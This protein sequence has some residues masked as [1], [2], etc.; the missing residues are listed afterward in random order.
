MRRS[1]KET[2]LQEELERLIRS[3][4]NEPV[5]TGEPMESVQLGRLQVADELR[6]LLRTHL[7]KAQA[8]E[9]NKGPGM[10]YIKDKNIVVMDL[11]DLE[12]CGFD[13]EDFDFELRA[14]GIRDREARCPVALI[15][16]FA[17]GAVVTPDTGK[18]SIARMKEMK[19]R[20][21]KL[22]ARLFTR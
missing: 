22:L 21:D 9:E 19:G 18:E 14:S 3:I 17:G 5:K 13:H 6:W 4:E 10:K 7:T 12:H 2:T 8:R 11:I 15:V 1:M 20:F 16:N